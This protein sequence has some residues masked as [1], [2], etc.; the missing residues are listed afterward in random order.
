MR[1]GHDRGGDF[2]LLQT[3]HPVAPAVQPYT[4]PF[5]HMISQFPTHT[6]Y[7]T[8]GHP[9]AKAHQ[10][11]TKATT[12]VYPEMK[13]FISMRE[14]NGRGAA[15]IRR[16]ALRRT[17]AQMMGVYTV[18]AIMPYNRNEAARIAAG[19][20]SVAALVVVS[21]PKFGLLGPPPPSWTLWVTTGPGKRFRSKP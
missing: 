18:C 3:T 7:T 14:V 1:G 2:P 13:T 8:T 9:A 21:V 16:V 20:Q 10:T 19:S 4:I 12:K 15:H 6:L 11:K 17:F 5:I